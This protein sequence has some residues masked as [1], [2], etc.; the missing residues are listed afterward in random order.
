MKEDYSSLLDFCKF[1]LTLRIFENPSLVQICDWLTPG[2]VKCIFC[3]HWHKLQAHLKSKCS[4]WRWETAHQANHHNHQ[5]SS[6]PSSLSSL[7][8][9]SS[10]SSPSEKYKIIKFCIFWPNCG[11]FIFNQT[12]A[13]QPATVIW[14]H[15]PFLGLLSTF[16][17][18]FCFKRL[19][20]H[21]HQQI[22]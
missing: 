4:R 8:S 18:N 14:P 16:H 11:I 2:Q 22:Q 7:S 3:N 9:S 5:S 17:F 19:H 12:V 15:W 1:I 20:Q 21:H 10:V 13:F 6:S